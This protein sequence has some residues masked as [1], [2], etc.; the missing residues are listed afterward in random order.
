[1]SLSEEKE[2]THGRTE[3]SAE[4]SAAGGGDWSDALAG[5]E[6]QTWHLLA[7]ARTEAQ[8]LLLLSPPRKERPCL[9]L[10]RALLAPGSEKENISVARCH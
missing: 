2:E 6:C 5:E 9:Q 10:E 1:M 4:L 7:E 8:I 3:N